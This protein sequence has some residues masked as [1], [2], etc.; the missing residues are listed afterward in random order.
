MRGALLLRGLI[1]GLRYS[2]HGSAAA[3]LNPG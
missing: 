3:F 1:P 2:P